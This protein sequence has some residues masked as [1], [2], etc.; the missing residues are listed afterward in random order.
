MRRMSYHTIAKRVGVQLSWRAVNSSRNRVN[1][2]WDGKTIALR[3]HSDSENREPMM[4]LHEIAHWMVC[5]PWRKK[6]PDFGLGPVESANRSVEYKKISFTQSEREEAKVGLLAVLLARDAG[7][8]SNDELTV[9]WIN[10]WTTVSDC[11]PKLCVKHSTLDY[12]AASWNDEFKERQKEPNPLLPNASGS[13]YVRVSGW[14]RWNTRYQLRNWEF[15]IRD[16][17]DYCEYN[18]GAYWKEVFKV[19]VALQRHGLLDAEG[20]T[21]LAR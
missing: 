18:R 3:E 13:G 7:W 5:P 1:C 21:C 8:R 2:G 15:M 17:H 19:V 11:V 9:S 10:D 14:L 12:Y 16:V 20:R 4:I 6:F